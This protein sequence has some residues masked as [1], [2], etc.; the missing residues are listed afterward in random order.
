MKNKGFTLV[1]ILLV[2]AIMA[3]LSVA[4][5]VSMTA[6]LDRME[7]T[8]VYHNI[9]DMFFEARRMALNGKNIENCAGDKIVAAGYGVNV[10]ESAENAD[11]SVASPAEFVIFSDMPGFGNWS[12]GGGEECADDVT[13]TE[14]VLPDNFHVDLGPSLVENFIYLPPDATHI[15]TDETG[16]VVTGVVTTMTI[17]SDS[18]G[19]QI[20]FGSSGVPERFGDLKKLP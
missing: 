20:K 11:G 14:Y 10:T 19:W 7:F 8:G 2:I 12:Y 18:Y 15:A 16:G 1:E 13:E 5:T 17:E 6:T 9:E 4:A 3:L